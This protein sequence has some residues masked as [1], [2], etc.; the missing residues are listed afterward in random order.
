MSIPKLSKKKA[1]AISVGV[2]LIALG[3]LLYTNAWWP[4]IL[5]AIWAMLATRELFTRRYYDLVLSSII[6]LGLYVVYFLKV[7][8]SVLMPVLFV[9]GGI[10]LI[11]RESYYATEEDE[12][13]RNTESEEE[14]EESKY[15]K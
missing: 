8:W 15:D 5:L 2:F 10:Y 4:G 9:V 3:I 1:D 12:I 11:F 7:D 13:E 6:F 14:I